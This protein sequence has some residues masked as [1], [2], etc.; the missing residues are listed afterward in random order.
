MFE[1][2]LFRFITEIQLT[3]TCL[4]VANG[5]RA[6]SDKAESI[7]RY[8]FISCVL[9]R[10]PEQS[11]CFLGSSI[12]V[13]FQ[14]RRSIQKFIGGFLFLSCLPRC[15]LDR[16]MRR[17]VKETKPIFW[18]A[19][20]AAIPSTQTQTIGASDKISCDGAA[21]VEY[22]DSILNRALLLLNLIWYLIMISSIAVLYQRGWYVQIYKQ[23]SIK[24]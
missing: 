2:V 19:D 5:Q 8:E 4:K 15:S 9:F 20:L 6:L 11:N 23:N 17:F 22:R 1:N 10:C 3:C 12:G 13:R 7:H 21:T 18:S 14:R 16:S 24:V